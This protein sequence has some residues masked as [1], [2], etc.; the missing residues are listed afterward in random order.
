MVDTLAFILRNR[1]KVREFLA[2][3]ANESEFRDIPLE[4]FELHA[5]L[6]PF[7]CFVNAVEAGKCSIAY[8]V[9]LVRGLLKQLRKIREILRTDSA[10]LILRDMTIRLLARLSMN[11]VVEAIAAYTLTPAGRAELRVL[12]TGYATKNPN[13]TIGIPNYEAHLDL[14]THIQHLK[15]NPET[16]HDTFVVLRKEII[17]ST[18]LY[19]DPLPS[20]FSTRTQR[21][22]DIDGTRA[23]TYGQR[24]AHYAQ[25]RDEELF[26]QDLYSPLYDQASAFIAEFGRRV[27]VNDASELFHSWLFDDPM[28]I[29]WLREFPNVTCINDMWR[30]A[31]PLR[32]WREFSHLALRLI[33]A[34]TSESEAERML[35]LE[36]DVIGHHGTRFSYDGLRNRIW[37]VLAKRSAQIEADKRR[38]GQGRGSTGSS[39]DEDP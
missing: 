19:D 33:T 16:Y 34:T 29:D 11:N 20:D 38:G 36:K 30:L 9:P 3:D 5:I 35:S 27:G 39:E 32:K 12:E 7:S 31:H 13:S 23:E 22:D 18:S 10:R 24:V 15:R 37:G 14:K 2:S 6:C 25:S 28:T 4:V 1:V 8:I 26:N 21:Q 17:D